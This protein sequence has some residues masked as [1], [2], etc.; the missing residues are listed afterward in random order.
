M[1]PV[2]HPRFITFA[3]SQLSHLVIGK[4][5]NPDTTIYNDAELEKAYEYTQNV[6]DFCIDRWKLETKPL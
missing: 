1:Y 2:I 4:W 6:V 3:K 5:V